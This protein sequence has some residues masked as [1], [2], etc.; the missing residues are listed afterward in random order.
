M[1]PARTV[2]SSVLTL[3]ISLAFA[4]SSHGDT[5][6]IQNGDFSANV[7]S[8]NAFPFYDSPSSPGDPSA[9]TDWTATNGV[10]IR[11][12]ALQASDGYGG[13]FPFAPQS[14]DIDGN[15]SDVV[16]IFAFIQ[17][18]SPPAT[19]FTST[20]SQSF[21]V[22]AG[23]TYDLSYVAAARND[24]SNND[25]DQIF[26]TVSYTALPA[27]ILFAQTGTLSGYEF[28]T[29]DTAYN[30]TTDYGFTN[31]GDTFTAT[32]SG[33]VTLNF[34]SGP[35]DAPVDDFTADLANVSVYDISP[36]SVP[37]PSTWM[38]LGAGFLFLLGLCRLRRA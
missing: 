26:A 4:G 3:A 14:D 33:E 36:P 12:F 23:Q 20:L 22:T 27:D 34:S 9:P 24:G 13:A 8:Y 37:E 15:G 32:T 16:G 17:G 10:G 19:A 1:K 25:H 29:N 7:T 31:S 18:N 21:Y 30:A 6:L 28:L 11:D 38:M 35:G 5:N 2:A